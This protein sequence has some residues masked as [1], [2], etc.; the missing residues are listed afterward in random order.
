M[1]YLRSCVP[2]FFYQYAIYTKKDS[3]HISRVPYYNISLDL[4]CFF[5]LFSVLFMSYLCICWI[6]NYLINEDVYIFKH[7][8]YLNVKV[9]VQ[10]EEVIKLRFWPK[11][12]E[13]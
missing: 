1:L 2:D 12:A 11:S 5:P 8:K 4:Y 3:G 13:N 7:Y 9:H 6:S 10:S